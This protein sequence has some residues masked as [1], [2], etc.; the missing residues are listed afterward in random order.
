MTFAKPRITLCLLAL[1]LLSLA[2]DTAPIETNEEPKPHNFGIQ[3]HD[4]LPEN[5]REFQHGDFSAFPTWP[6]SKELPNDSFTFA[7][8]IYPSYNDG[9]GRHRYSKWMT[10]Y[11]DSDMNLS[12]RL[13]QMTSLQVNPNCAIVD[14]EPEQLRHYPF[15]Y[16]T[17]MGDNDVTDDQAKVLRNYM[18]NGGFVMVDDFWG[19]DEWDTF[20]VFFK[21]MWP[22]RE[23]VELELDH[24]IFHS[25]FDLKKKP[26]IPGIGYAMR[27]KYDGSM[28]TYE[29]NKEGS[30]TVHYRGVYDDKKRLCMIIC[31]NTDTGDGWEEEG[32][33]PWYFK[34]FSEPYAYPIGI[35]IIYYAMT[36]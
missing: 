22:D 29:W 6:V 7:R 26:Q 9:Y 5:P 11:P 10:D 4:R 2:A 24:D 20:Y 1:S 34:T 15:L 28:R 8:V 21:K 33:D 19:T 32:T 36:H 25:V 35:N 14:I 18:L 31:W 13:Q 23:F 30:E 12:F 17:E 16:M 3:E 27:G